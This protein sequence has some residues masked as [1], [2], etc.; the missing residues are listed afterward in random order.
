MKLL[1]RIRMILDTLREVGDKDPEGKE[2]LL[3]ELN[4]VKKD[5]GA[6]RNAPS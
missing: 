4:K 6:F 1:K 2:I 3:S 5:L